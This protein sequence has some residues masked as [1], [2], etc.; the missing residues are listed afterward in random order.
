M[1]QYIFI[2]ISYSKMQ[3]LVYTLVEILI[4]CTAFGHPH[5]VISM[6]SRAIRM[7]YAWEI[8]V[9]H[10]WSIPGNLQVICP[11]ILHSLRPG[12]TFGHEVGGHKPSTSMR[13]RIPLWEWGMASKGEGKVTSSWDGLQTILWLH[14]SGAMPHC[15]IQLSPLLASLSSPGAT[16]P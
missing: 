2:F 11:G 9:L 8:I 13:N 6:S 7:G 12:G 14:E 15:P 1:F 10:D 4:N 16:L 3:E 5:L